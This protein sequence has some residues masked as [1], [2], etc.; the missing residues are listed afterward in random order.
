MKSLSILAASFCLLISSQA[1]AGAR[2]ADIRAT[3]PNS[4]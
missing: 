2:N 1:S 4:T 3:S